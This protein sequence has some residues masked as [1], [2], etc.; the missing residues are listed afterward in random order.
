MVFIRFRI[1]KKKIGFTLVPAALSGLS[2]ITH[3]INIDMVEDLITL[4]KNLI[5]ST[6]TPPFMIRL[7]ALNCAFKTL[8]GPGEE[9]EAD[10][11]A[12]LIALEKLLLDGDF[13]DDFERWD[14]ILECVEVGIV[15]K[16]LEC[17]NLVNS[18]VQLLLLH[19][20]HAENDVALTI[21]GVVHAGLLRY[22][23]IRA[24]LIALSRAPPTQDDDVVQDTAMQGLVSQDAGKSGGLRAFEQEFT[25]ASWVLNLMSKSMDS[26]IRSVISGVTSVNIVP[27]PYKLSS[28]CL[29]RNRVF[30]RIETALSST[31]LR[32]LKPT[33]SHQKTGSFPSRKNKK[34]KKK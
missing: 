6:P 15:K 8:A 28:A 5:E 27:I 34:N 17:H 10:D 13:S 22:P 11:T 12:F 3:L 9:L 20:V 4:L 23:R 33:P 25:D 21:L 7:N 30:G 18:I 32:K 16:R 29:D 14:I 1:I 24:N 2:Q 19:A 26:R 31:P